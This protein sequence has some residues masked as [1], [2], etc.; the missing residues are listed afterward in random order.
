MPAASRDQNRTTEDP[1]DFT[2]KVVLITGA[3]TGIGRASALMFA[4]H[5]ASVAIGDVD[6]SAEETVRLI[7]DAGGIASFVPT[8]VAV[9]GEVERLVQ[10]TVQTYGSL[11]VAFNNAGVLP[12][13]GPLVEQSEEDWDRTIAV[14]LKG[15]F[16]CLKYELAHM[17]PL[18]AG[19]IINTASV[20]GFVADP[21]M[22]PYVAAKH[23]VVGLTQAAALDY[24]SSGVRVNAVAPGLV[25]TPMTQAWLDD[26][27]K[28]GVVLAQ[29]PLGRP[30]QPEEIAG[31]VLFLASPLASYVNGAV[32]LVDG[33]QTSH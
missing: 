31:T 19:A 5:G 16:L 12:P 4:H 14:N 13:T 21:G 28:R 2:G 32:Y 29:S 7:Q 18:G 26:P 30:A 17:V 8:N 15:V 23:G 9:A 24:A 6:D 22:A 1:L 20:A 10:T 27:V 33:G 11:D 25:E 3:A